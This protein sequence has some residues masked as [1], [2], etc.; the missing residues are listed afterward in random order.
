MNENLKLNEILKGHEGEFFYSPVFGIIQYK[1]YDNCFLKFIANGV[2]K[3]LL[4]PS[5]KYIDSADEI[6]VYPSEKEKDWNKWNE[7]INIKPKHWFNFKKIPGIRDY[8]LD[9]EV[10]NSELPLSIEEI[11]I[12]NSVIN[13]IRIQQL[14]QYSY[15][16]RV[17]YHDFCYGTEPLY[18]I[19]PISNYFKVVEVFEESKFSHIAFHTK[20]QAEEFLKYDE[21]KFLLKEYFTMIGEY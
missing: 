16:G 5:G 15:G 17:H 10:N 9:Y 21:N 4:N 18:I 1:E 20:E 13:L 3:I 8:Y 6:A 12:N 11:K 2:I 19:V 14:I 7:N